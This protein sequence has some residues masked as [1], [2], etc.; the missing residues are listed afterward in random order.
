[1]IKPSAYQRAKPETEFSEHALTRGF[2][3]SIALK[4]EETSTELAEEVDVVI[5]GI[6]AY[7]DSRN[8]T[9][10]QGET[11]IDRLTADGTPEG[12]GISTGWSNQDSRSGFDTPPFSLQ[13]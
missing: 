8:Y 12:L 7:K 9:K 13:S 11:G 2:G 1:M 4:V 3:A 6:V 10:V 5:I